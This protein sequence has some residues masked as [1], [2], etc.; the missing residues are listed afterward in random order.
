MNVQHSTKR[1]INHEKVIRELAYERWEH[2]GM[3]HGRSDAFWFAARY[4]FQRRALVTADYSVGS[5]NNLE[6]VFQAQIA[7]VA[8]GGFWPSPEDGVRL[9]E[10]FVCIRSPERRQA[11]LEYAL[12]QAKMDFEVGVWSNCGPSDRRCTQ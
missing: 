5:D 4:E 9:L 3:P 1:D 2:A 8:D 12:D 6:G 11:V 10:A 7:E